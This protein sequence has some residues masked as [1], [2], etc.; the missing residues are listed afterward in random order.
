M[1]STIDREMVMSASR[2]VRHDTLVGPTQ[3]M[4]RLR[5]IDGVRRTWQR[6]LEPGAAG[7]GIMPWVSNLEYWDQSFLPSDQHT[8]I[9]TPAFIEWKAPTKADIEHRRL[10]Y[11]FVIV[12]NATFVGSRNWIWPSVTMNSDLCGEDDCE[13]CE[14]SFRE[15]AG[16]LSEHG[17]PV[18]LW[19]VNPI[20]SHLVDEWRHV[21]VKHWDAHPELRQ[22][23]DLSSESMNHYAVLEANGEET[24]CPADPDGDGDYWMQECI[25]GTAIE[26]KLL[27][28]NMC[29][30]V[31]FP[32]IDDGFQ[33][34]WERTVGRW[35]LG[36]NAISQ[37]GGNA[38][39]SSSVQQLSPF[40]R[41]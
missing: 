36:W 8:P 12:H 10:P 38:C 35:T 20:E 2:M 27:D 6:M 22:L 30:G 18:P 33:P 15:D 37:I 39:L 19:S 16:M 17:F 41:R 26:Q 34:T 5:T 40:Y 23:G 21:A 4:I 29:E 9:L 31:Y 14:D 28:E 25:C 32:P 7:S 1:T 3:C 24:Q 11:P 13:V